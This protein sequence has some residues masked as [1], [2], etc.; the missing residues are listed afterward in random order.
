MTP[1]LCNNIIYSSVFHGVWPLHSVIMPYL[2]QC[3]LGSSPPLLYE[4]AIHHVD[5]EKRT[6]ITPPSQIWSCSQVHARRLTGPDLGINEEDSL[7]IT[8]ESYKKTHCPDFGFMQEDSLVLTLD[9][10]KKTQ[11]SKV[12][13]WGLSSAALGTRLSINCSCIDTI[14]GFI[15]R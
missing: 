8:F 11:C 2:L 7:V 13:A 15:L 12:N 1:T 6:N 4:F 10:Y 14:F 5:W 9:S 3:V